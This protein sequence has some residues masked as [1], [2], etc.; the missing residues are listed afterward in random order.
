MHCVRH[1]LS[2]TPFVALC[3]NSP[4]TVVTSVVGITAFREQD[5][6]NRVFADPSGRAV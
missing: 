3:V 4:A 5:W 6:L 1:I 2:R